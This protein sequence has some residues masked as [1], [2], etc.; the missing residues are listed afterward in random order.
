MANKRKLIF[1][2]EEGDTPCKYCVLREDICRTR[3][4]PAYCIK[5]DFSTLKLVG[6]YEENS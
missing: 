2:V 3:E 5:Y 4:F 1:E 6:E